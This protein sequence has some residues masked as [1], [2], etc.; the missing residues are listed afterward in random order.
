[1]A[2]P[3]PN[4]SLWE[5]HEERDHILGTP[6]CCKLYSGL[7]A[8]GSSWYDPPRTKH[9]NRLMAG[10]KEKQNMLPS[11]SL[12]LFAFPVHELRTSV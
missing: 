10:E 2:Q 9:L 11:P 5:Q 3:I 7:E 8:D 1:M 4:S 12:E 6:H